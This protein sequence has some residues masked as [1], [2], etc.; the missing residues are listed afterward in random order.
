MKLFLSDVH[1]LESLR[2]GKVSLQ[3]VRFIIFSGGCYDTTGDS[4]RFDY[5]KAWNEIK[6]WFRLDVII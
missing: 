4:S 1:G 5:M 6:F 3:I 2:H